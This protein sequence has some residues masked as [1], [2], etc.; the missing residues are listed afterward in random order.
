VYTVT[1]NLNNIINEITCLTNKSNVQMRQAS[2]NRFYAA[3]KHRP[4]EMKNNNQMHTTDMHR[5]KSI[6]HDKHHGI[7]V[8]GGEAMILS[9]ACFWRCRRGRRRRRRQCSEDGKPVK[10]PSRAPKVRKMNLSPQASVTRG[11]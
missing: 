5:K 2:I 6:S 9:F 4:L 1:T 3:K 8:A 11:R 10:R 7:F